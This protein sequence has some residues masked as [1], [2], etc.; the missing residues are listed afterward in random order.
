M[1][2]RRFFQF[3]AVSAVL[4][5][6]V[7]IALETALAKSDRRCLHNFQVV[8]TQDEDGYVDL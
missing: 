7:A 2:N 5:F 6:A 1:T 3:F 8:Q 4:G